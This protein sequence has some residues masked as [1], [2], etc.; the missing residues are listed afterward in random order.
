MPATTV[1]DKL[2]SAVPRWSGKINT[3]GVASGV[4]T[5]IPLNSS[6]NLTNGGIYIFTINRVDSNGDKN[7]LAEMET[8]IGEL[9]GANFIN[10]VRGLEGTAGPWDADTVVEVLFTSAQWNKLI[11]WAEA[12]H[13]QDGTH[14]GALVTTLKATGAEIDTGTEDAKIVTPKAIADSGLATETYSENYTETYVDALNSITTEVS[15]ATPTPTGGVLTNHHSVTALAVAAT[16]SAPSGTPANANKLI[17][18][19]KD[20]ATARVI[21]WNAIYAAGGVDLPLT[22]TISKLLQVGLIYDSA[23][24]KWKCVAVSEEG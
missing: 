16:V 8:V 10:C 5:T 9:S 11:E 14:K 1:A 2:L 20:N 6:T 19:F 12:E 22:T 21:G 23:A 4:V 17:I 15:S 7:S 3:G 13:N 24:A 18:T